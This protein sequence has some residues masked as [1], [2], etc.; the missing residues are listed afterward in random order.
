MDRT[1]CAGHLEVDRW[2]PALTAAGGS[3]HG[4]GV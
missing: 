2:S 1:L 3:R 4:P